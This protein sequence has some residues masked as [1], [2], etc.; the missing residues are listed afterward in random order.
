MLPAN[1]EGIAAAVE[2]LRSGGVVAYPTE[3]VYGLG[4]DARNAAALDRL[5]RI[6]ERPDCHPVLLI[7]ADEAQLLSV[8]LPPEDHARQ[9]MQAFWPG[10]ISLVLPAV[11]GLHDSVAPEGKVCVRCPGL[12][13]ARELCAAFGGPVTSTSANLSGQPPARD[14]QAAALPGVDLVLDAG[15]LPPSEAST[16][17][18]PGERRMLREGAI[19]RD[20]MAQ[21][22]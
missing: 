18:S 14:A 15:A 17:Y 2:V 11:P 8:A 1:A 4:V 6:K 13:F 5:Y 7:V 22:G 20:R 3:T 19:S 21:L 16:V 12:D 9:C 10:P